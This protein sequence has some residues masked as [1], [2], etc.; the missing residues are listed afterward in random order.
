M[1]S[2]ETQNIAQ[3]PATSAAIFLS[4]KP[5]PNIDC[6]VSPA[7][8]QMETPSGKPVNSAISLVKLPIIF[9][10]FTIFGIYSFLIFKISNC[11]S[12]HSFL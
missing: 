5:Q 11:L 6:M 2:V 8:A 7:P 9:Q 10:G 12:D 4:I 1:P 3:V